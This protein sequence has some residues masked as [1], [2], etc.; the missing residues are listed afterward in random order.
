MRRV[1]GLSASAAISMHSAFFKHLQQE[2]GMSLHSAAGCAGDLYLATIGG[3]IL[4]KGDKI[5]EVVEHMGHIQVCRRRRGG[6]S[7]AMCGLG[8]LS[9]ANISEVPQSSAESIVDVA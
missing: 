3:K 2:L 1:V 9:K 6:M 4:R 8:K 5:C 7:N